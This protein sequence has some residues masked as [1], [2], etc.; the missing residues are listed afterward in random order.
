MA[1]DGNDKPIRGHFYS[2]D[3]VRGIAAL[4]VALTHWRIFFTSDLSQGA[5]LGYPPFY[6][7]LSLP[8]EYGRTAIHLF[9]SLSGFVFFYLYYN[10]IKNKNISARD[11]FVR[12]FSRLYPL[13]LLTLLLVVIAQQ[14][15]VSTN[16]SF[17]FPKE[18]NI[19]YFMMNI[20]FLPY[21]LMENI[22]TFNFP[23]WSVFIEVILYTV[24][25][26]LAFWGMLGKK[27][28]PIIIGILIISGVWY[29][30]YGIYALDFFVGGLIFR[31][32]CRIIKSKNIHN[33]IIFIVGLTCTIWLIVLTNS[34]LI[35]N[36]V[37]SLPINLNLDKATIF[38]IAEILFP[39]TIL[40]LT[41]IE[42]LGI[43]NLKGFLFIGNIS[44]SS[45]MLHFPLQLV[46]IMTTDFLGVS[47]SFYYTNLSF[48]LFFS[49]LI[50]IS[51]LSYH[52]FERPMQN[53]IRQTTSRYRH[54]NH[55]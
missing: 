5:Q 40:A 31:F 37:K 29:S 9:F 38:F 4:S 25:F 50:L 1:I 45:Y 12:R 49:I 55:A 3:I 35:V 32:Y 54:S 26:I 36:T 7:F 47:H 30:A 22:Y 10:R 20:L 53:Y 33:W 2:L 27:M 13:H 43:K 48:I 19:Y 51:L 17:V 8:Y 46:F 34:P 41:L 11:F 16:G 28:L 52:K 44:Y 15:I 6:A 14:I 42:H 18:N 24:F 21:F 23:A 39:A